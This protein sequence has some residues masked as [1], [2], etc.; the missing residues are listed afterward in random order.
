M[1]DS[2]ADIFSASLSVLKPLRTTWAAADAERHAVQFYTSFH[3]QIEI[4]S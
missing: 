2:W 4:A 3:S 1:P